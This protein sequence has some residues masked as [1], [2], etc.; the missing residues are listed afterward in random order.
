[1]TAHTSST[2]NK[3]QKLIWINVNGYRA[4]QAFRG[5]IVT[6]NTVLAF[7]RPLSSF[8]SLLEKVILST[9][10]LDM[11]LMMLFNASFISKFCNLML[12]GPQGNYNFMKKLPGIGPAPVQCKYYFLTAV[13]NIATSASW[14]TVALV[15]P[16][17]LRVGLANYEPAVRDFIP[18]AAAI[19][20]RCICAVYLVVTIACVEGCG[21]NAHIGT[22]RTSAR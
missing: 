22:C 10:L 15:Y 20:L 3:K 12:G 21:S 7:C 11:I 6:L 17:I 2:A 5:A 1:M 4:G 18:E 14:T 9:V 8:V 19:T 16:V 13:S